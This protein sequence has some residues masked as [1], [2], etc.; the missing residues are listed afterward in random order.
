LEAHD[1]KFP[2]DNDNIIAMQAQVANDE[3]QDDHDTY[4]QEI[5]QHLSLPDRSQ[6]TANEA[7]QYFHRLMEIARP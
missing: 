4:F 6:W 1:C 3:L 5:C 7:K 2:A